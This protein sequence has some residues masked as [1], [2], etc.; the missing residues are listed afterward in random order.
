MHNEL[1]VA[2]NNVS[3]DSKVMHIHRVRI[4]SCDKHALLQLDMEAAQ[5][6]HR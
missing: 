5:L 4:L 2:N 3:S 1:Q 6:H